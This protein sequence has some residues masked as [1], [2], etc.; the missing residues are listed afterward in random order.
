MGDATNVETVSGT[1]D[2]GATPDKT[3]VHRR[4][5]HGLRCRR[6][7]PTYEFAAQRDPPLPTWD[8][9]DDRMPARANHLRDASGPGRRDAFAAALLDRPHA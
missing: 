1:Y 6:D 5:L 9:G 7:A 8:V 3:A 2:I 4:H